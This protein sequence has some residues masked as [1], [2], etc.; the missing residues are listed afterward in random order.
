MLPSSP[1]LSLS[2]SQKE[3]NN[4]KHRKKKRK[5]RRKLNAST[6]VQLDNIWATLLSFL[7]MIWGTTKK[8]RKGGNDAQMVCSCRTLESI[9]CSGTLVNI[10]SKDEKLWHVYGSMAVLVC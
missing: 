8:E 10:T 7:C 1:S 5:E 2:V 6:V 4:E 9:W 3:K